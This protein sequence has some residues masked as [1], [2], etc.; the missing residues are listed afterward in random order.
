LLALD[1]ATDTLALALVVG[2]AVTCFEGAAGAQA[3]A[4]LLPE[5]QALL[6]AAGL[7]LK[8]LDAI[9]FGRGPGAFTGLRTACAV[10]QGL[11]LGLERPV[12]SIDSLMIVAEDA[13]CQSAEPLQQLWV[14]M[15]ARMSE[16]YAAPYAWVS[17]TWQALQSPALYTPAALAAAWAA[18]PPAAVAGSALLEFEAALAPV[19]QGVPGF[20]RPVSRAQA[21][22]ALARAAWAR[23]ERLDA[24]EALPLYVR[25]KVALTTAERQKA[26]A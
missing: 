16:I 11:G 1:S 19:L 12:L 6:A 4:R 14:A 17:G 21:L 2:E 20:A 13:R 18:Q 25:D 26:A 3:S 23:G 8:D 7:A 22:A 9:A 15:D 10:A 24:A 5:A